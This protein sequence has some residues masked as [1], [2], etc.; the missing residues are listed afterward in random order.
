MRNFIWL[1]LT[2][3]IFSGYIQAQDD[4]RCTIDELRIVEFTDL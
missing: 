3:F 1:I 2:D 4:K